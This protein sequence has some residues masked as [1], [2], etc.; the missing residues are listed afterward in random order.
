[1]EVKALSPQKQQMQQMVAYEVTNQGGIHV[2]ALTVYMP[3]GR[4]KQKVP[5]KFYSG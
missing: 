1:M 4:C 5:I 2:C 3:H